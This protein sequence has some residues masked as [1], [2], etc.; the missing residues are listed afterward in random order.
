MELEL[1]GTS[2]DCLELIQDSRYSRE[3]TLEMIVPDACP[4]IAQ[5]ADTW[6]FCCLTRR[7]VT[8]SGALLTGRVRVNILY[9]PEGGRGL[10]RLEAELPFQHLSE[11]AQVD[12]N[13]R[14]LADAWVSFAETRILNPRK[15]L[16]RTDL[17]EKVR[18]YR[19]QTLRTYSALTADDALGVQTRQQQEQTDLV[20]QTAEKVFILEDELR[21]SG[22]RAISGVPLRLRPEACCPE[23]RLIGSKLVLKGTVRVQGLW[24]EDGG[25]LISNSFELPFSQMLDAAG[26]GEGAQYQ[27]R[28]QIQSCQTGPLSGDGRTLPITLELCA[29]AVFCERIPITLMTDAYSI[30]Y[31]TELHTELWDICRQSHEES[32]LPVR[33]SVACERNIQAVLDCHGELGLAQV[34]RDADQYN[35]T[36]PVSAAALCPD[37]EEN[38]F[39]V[40]RSFS[41]S[42]QSS[43]PPEQQL[44]CNCLLVQ[45]EALSAA[46]GLELRGTIAL[47]IHAVEKS[48]VA[49]LTGLEVDEEHPK[50]HSGQPSVVLRRP[51][52]SESLW[53]IAKRCS[54][55]CQEICTANGLAEDQTLG[56]QMLLI[57]RKR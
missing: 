39:S 34:V 17:C 12:G 48:A 7:E 20:T 26:V 37:E 55:T 57:P 29:Q 2:A 30:Y 14:L 1:T 13:A 6:G 32:R 25:E 18:L 46:A 31:P 50:E 33:E 42:F 40:L 38:P 56:D 49:C 47:H 27:V 52:P 51:A 3:E 43:C 10:Q 9:I 23:A 21:L 11:C 28:L 22:S 53:D 15:V 19:H 5:V 16:I 8:D 4:D 24:Q 35:V 45:I 36:V 54:T 44:Q 41:V